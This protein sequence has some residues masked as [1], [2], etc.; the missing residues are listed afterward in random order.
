MRLLLV[1]DNPGDARLIKEH[2]RE[3]RHS[4]GIEQTQIEL[5]HVETLSDAMDQLEAATPEAV[6]LDLSL[7]DSAGSD[8]LA[9]VC[10]KYPNIPVIVLTGLEDEQLAV[11]LLEEGAQD[12]LPKG[13]VT[14][15]S[16]RT[17]MPE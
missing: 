10:S 13:R 15:M 4:Q 3:L 11:A 14:T 12:Y 16:T 7:P 2:L 1:E 8:T 17:G 9:S 6:L 5:S